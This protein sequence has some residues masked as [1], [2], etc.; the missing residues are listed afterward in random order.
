LTVGAL[1]STGG[2]LSVCPAVTATAVAF[3]PVLFA[4]WFSLRS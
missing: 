3:A 1:G 4:L 2:V